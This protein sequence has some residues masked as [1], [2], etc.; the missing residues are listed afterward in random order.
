[1]Y[2]SGAV[3]KMVDQLVVHSKDED[4]NNNVVCS[5]AAH[6][7]LNTMCPLIPLFV[8]N[9]VGIN[10]TKRVKCRTD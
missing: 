10:V 7:I 3:R 8:L 5:L 9:I 6:F 4:I 1:M 2:E